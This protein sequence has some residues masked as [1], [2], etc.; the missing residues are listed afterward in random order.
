[1]TPY[2]IKS[3]VILDI[4]GQ[5]LEVL[6]GKDAKQTQFNISGLTKLCDEFGFKSFVSKLNDFRCSLPETATV[7]FA[8]RICISAL[9]ERL[10]QQSHRFDALNAQLSCL[11]HSIEEWHQKTMEVTTRNIEELSAKFTSEL[12][13]SESR[14]SAEIT[15]LR[16][17]GQMSFN[18]STKSPLNDIIAY[19]TERCGGN[20]HEHSIVT[21]INSKMIGGTLEAIADL[22][23]NSDYCSWSGDG[24]WVGYDFKERRITSTYYTLRSRTHSHWAGKMQSWVIEGYQD[25]Q[26]WEELACVRDCLEMNEPGVIR[27]FPISK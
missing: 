27:S 25:G 18:F 2:R 9:E 11:S 13:A 19:L 21:V 26:N 7:D 20:V 15:H 22:K 6:Q 10:L 14:L 16:T 12:K 3:F 17:A 1:V 5:F 23:G 24:P 8:P 4:L